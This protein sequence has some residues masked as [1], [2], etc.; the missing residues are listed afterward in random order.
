M[1]V[2]RRFNEEEGLGFEALQGLRVQS[3]LKD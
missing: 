3:R 1:H 2:V